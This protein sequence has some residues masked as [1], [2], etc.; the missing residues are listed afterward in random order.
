MKKRHQLFVR[1]V[2]AHKLTHKIKS[3]AIKMVNRQQEHTH[4]GETC[5]DSQLWSHR[6]TTS[7]DSQA[8]AEVWLKDVKERSEEIFYSEIQ[9]LVLEREHFIT[10]RRGLRSKLTAEALRKRLPLEFDQGQNPEAW[11]QVAS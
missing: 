6:S 5:T 11:K 9:E 4:L 8:N 1:W 3:K 2:S 10:Y 7:F